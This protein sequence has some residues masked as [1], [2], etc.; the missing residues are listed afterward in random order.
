MTRP[1]IKNMSQTQTNT[2]VL[3]LLSGLYHDLFSHEGYGELRVEMR[4]LKRGQKEVI[5]HCGKQ[6]RFVVNY[7]GRD[8]QRDAKAIENTSS[9]GGN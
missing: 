7:H 1:N 6:H 5:I 3:N 2:E 4:L 9:S 8:L